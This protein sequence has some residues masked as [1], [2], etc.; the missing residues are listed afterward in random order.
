MAASQQPMATGGPRPTPAQ[1]PPQSM[2]L[3]HTHA[4]QPQLVSMMQNPAAAAAAAAHFAPGANF[5]PQIPLQHAR[6]VMNGIPPGTHV[7]FATMQNPTVMAAR[8]AQMRQFQSG[9]APNPALNQLGPYQSQQ[10]QT[11]M[12]PQQINHLQQFQ[13]AAP[14][15]RLNPQHQLIPPQHLIQPQAVTGPGIQQIVGAQGG[16]HIV[17]R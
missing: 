16:Q 10:I 4:Q 6:P 13:P 12:V 5:P 2:V 17:T 11:T 8:Q 3:Q 1:G 7:N 14:Q 15:L 9:I